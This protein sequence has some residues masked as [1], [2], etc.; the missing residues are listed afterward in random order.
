MLPEGVFSGLARL[1]SL[2][3]NGNE[4]TALP[5]GTFSGLSN[6]LDELWLSR[7]LGSPFSLRLE[8]ERRDDPGQSAA[9]TAPLGVRLDKGAPF[10]LTIGLSAEGGTLSADSASI[11]AGG[12]KSPDIS[13]TRSGDEPVPV[14]LS[15]APEVPATTC[16]LGD[17]C[18]RGFEFSVGGPLALFRTAPVVR[19]L[20]LASTPFN[21]DTYGLGETIVVDAQFDTPVSVVGTPRLALTIGT[22]TRPAMY[23]C[24][25]DSQVVSFRYAVQAT[26]LDADGL[27][28]AADSF[29]L[30]GGAIQDADDDSFDAVLTH[31]A[32]IDDPA[33]KVDGSSLGA[34]ASMADVNGD[35]TLDPDDALAMYYAYAL[36]DLLGDGQ[37]GGVARFRQTLLGGRTGTSNPSDEDLQ[38]MLRNAN[39]WRGAGVSSVG[40]VNG[41]GTLD[42]D[43]ALAMYYAYALADLLGDGQTGGV[44]RF[45]RTLLGGRAGISNPSDEDLKLMLRNANEL[46]AA[47]P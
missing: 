46:R 30:D 25:S 19:Q 18:Y 14:T 43:D 26:D 41:D 28:I 36:P 34:L 32:L 44:A 10:D 22:Q 7:N 4:L 24:C 8:L 23:D 20:A 17:P 47:L 39:D 13:V 15:A 21:G 5:D 37:T 40:D 42:E 11:A 33:H 2:R 16:A 45:R 27:G 31:A 3:L 35:G 12:T 1:E 29:V 9:N 6:G 38:R